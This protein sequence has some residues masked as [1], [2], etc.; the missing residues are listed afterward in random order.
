MFLRI[1]DIGLTIY[2]FTKQGQRTYIAEKGFLINNTGAKGDP[3]KGSYQK[4]IRRML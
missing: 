4:Y 1:K 3:L 2:N